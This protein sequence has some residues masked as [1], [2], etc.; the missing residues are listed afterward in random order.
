MA[1]CRGTTNSSCFISLDST[2]FGSAVLGVQCTSGNEPPP[3]SFSSASLA[4]VIK[5][6]DRGEN[7]LQAQQDHNNGKG[8]E[9]LRRAQG[10]PR[11]LLPPPPRRQPREQD[12][13]ADNAGA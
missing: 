7:L 2:F 1:P 10:P 12:R 5:L 8:D 6:T 9:Q 11:V 13:H 4:H 3:F